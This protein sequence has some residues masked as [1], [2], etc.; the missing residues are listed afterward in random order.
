VRTE[1]G[2]LYLFVAIDRI[3]RSTLYKWRKHHS[4]GQ[5]N[6]DHANEKKELTSQFIELSV[7][8]EARRVKLTKADLAFSDCSLLI[9]GNFN[10]SKLLML[11]SIMED[12]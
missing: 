7:Q 6:N 2:K 5:E 3:S 12:Q 4:A 11:I 8:E 1:K 10:S 9:E